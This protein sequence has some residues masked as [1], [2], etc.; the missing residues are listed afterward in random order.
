MARGGVLLRHTA[1][2]PDVLVLQLNGSKDWRVHEGPANGDWRLGRVEGEPPAEVL[3][4]TMYASDVLY[5]PRGFPHQAVGSGGL[6][7]HLSLTIR[8]IHM[9]DLFRSLQKLSA[10]GMNIPARPLDD[11]AVLAAATTM[12][13]HVGKA[14]AG[15]DPPRT[16]WTTPGGPDSPPCPRRARRSRSV[17]FFSVAAPG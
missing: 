10:K 8:E 14:L 3:R 12:L 17:S 1:G 4:T 7:V 11:E 15:P 13:D 6:S 5:I 2:H 9:R 16:W